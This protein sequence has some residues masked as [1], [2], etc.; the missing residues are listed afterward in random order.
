MPPQLAGRESVEWLFRQIRLG[1]KRVESSESSRFVDP[2]LL[3]RFPAVIERTDG[4]LSSPVPIETDLM[5]RVGSDD[6]RVILETPLGGERFLEELED[7]PLPR[8]C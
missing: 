3:E 7:D 8:I 5:R 2:D 6:K 4:R 1:P